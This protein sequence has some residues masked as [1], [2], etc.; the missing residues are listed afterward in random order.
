MSA[1]TIACAPVVLFTYNRPEHTRRTLSALAANTLAARTP[2]IIYSDAARHDKDKPAV[3]AVRA[4]AGSAAGFASV[5]VH[6]RERNFGLADSIADG[7]SATI[8]DH[9]RAIVLEDDIVTSLHF[10]EYM[11]EALARY[12]HEERVMHIAAHMPP[13]SAEGLPESF[14]LRQSSCWGWGTWARAWRHFHRQGQEFIDAFSP[15]DIKRFNLDGAYDYWSQLLANENGALKTWA[16]YWYACVFSQGGL[17]LHPRRSLVRNIGFDGSGEN[18]GVAAGESS[19]TGVRAPGFYPDVPEENR[20]AMQRYQQYLR[21][22]EP[23]GFWGR[24]RRFLRGNGLRKAFCFILTGVVGA[25][26]L[27]LLAIVIWRPYYQ[28]GYATGRQD[29]YSTGRQDGYSAGRQDGYSAGRQDGYPAGQVIFQYVPTRQTMLLS[30]AA[31]LPKGTVALIGD[32]ITDGI[33]FTPHDLPVFNAGIGSA[34]VKTWIEFAPR[35]IAE[36]EIKT[37]II[38]LGINDTYRSNFTPGNFSD[39]YK[40]LCSIFRQG[41]KG[42]VIVSTILPVGKN[43]PFGAGYFD[44]SRIKVLNET[45]RHIAQE[46]GYTLMD[47]FAYFADVEGYMPEEMTTDGVH[48]AAKGYE[49]WK[50]LLLTILPNETEKQL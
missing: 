9:S 28:D 8:R 10:L 32:S 37:A 39:D 47:S 44:V 29:G 46:Q 45:I 19:V 18:C 22:G 49:K 12:E 4:F 14:F 26:V 40:K 21:G 24:L 42:Q 30:Q 36:N 34:T 31:Q 41:G 7:V 11:N 15:A 1:T 35:L 5:T 17:C 6:E 3:D 16:V 23:T 38:T 13:I 43:K 27:A 25:S 33:F 20:P 50:L 48:L 2:L